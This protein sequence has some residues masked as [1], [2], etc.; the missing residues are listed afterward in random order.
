MD[1]TA[2]ACVPRQSGPT[3]RSD[4]SKEN[5]NQ[6]RGTALAGRSVPDESEVARKARRSF[7]GAHAAVQQTLSV[8]RCPMRFG[9]AGKYQAANRASAQQLAANLD[10]FRAAALT[11]GFSEDALGLVSILLGPGSAPPQ[12]QMFFGQRIR[13]APGFLKNCGA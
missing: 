12:P 10:M 9:R 5:L 3:R 7:A 4:A 6:K 8:S 2:N 13:S 1:N 11:N